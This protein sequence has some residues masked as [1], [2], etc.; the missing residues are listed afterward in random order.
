MPWPPRPRTRPCRVHE[1]GLP[2]EPDIAAAFGETRESSRLSEESARTAARVSRS[3]SESSQTSPPFSSTGA[4]E[5]T[6]PV[7]SRYRCPA[8]PS[9]PGRARGRRRRS[10]HGERPSEEYAGT[11]PALREPRIYSRMQASAPS[12]TSRRPRKFEHRRGTVPMLRCPAI[13]LTCQDLRLATLSQSSHRLPSGVP[14]NRPQAT[15]PKARKQLVPLTSPYSD[16]RQS[17]TVPIERE[18]TSCGRIRERRVLKEP[19]RQIQLTARGQV[20]LR[21]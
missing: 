2:R 17:E 10:H 8:R 11:K 20:I 3:Q 13:L 4:L 6:L 21:P 18:I 16:A 7:E 15:R 1:E 14:R 12:E 9:S 19:Q 5:E